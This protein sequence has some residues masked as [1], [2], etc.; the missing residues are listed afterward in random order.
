M[1]ENTDV[2][3]YIPA[4]V[5]KRHGVHEEKQNCPDENTVYE[6]VWHREMIHQVWTGWK[7]G[8]AS[9]NYEGNAT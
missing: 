6:Q 4:D 9:L 8:D 1:P 5:L 7:L 2:E 3:S